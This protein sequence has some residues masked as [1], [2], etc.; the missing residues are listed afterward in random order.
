MCL[1]RASLAFGSAN[2]YLTSVL[3]EEAVRWPIPT[4]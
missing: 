2:R 1:E 3:P 4:S